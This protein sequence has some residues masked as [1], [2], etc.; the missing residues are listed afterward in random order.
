MSRFVPTPAETWALWT[1]FFGLLHHAD[2]VL[3]V[4]HSGWPFLAEVTPFTYS[5]AV[6]PLIAVL[7]WARGW[8]RFRAGLAGL[9]FLFP[10]VSHVTLET[11][12]TQYRTWAHRPAVNMLG[13]QSPAMGTVAVAITLLLS[14]AA[15]MTF[16]GFWRKA[17]P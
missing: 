1:T 8:P 7:L 17:R 15:F 9:L 4:N 6:Y 14:A 2:H 16:L 12:V 13:V 3:R 11:P 10:T 5:L